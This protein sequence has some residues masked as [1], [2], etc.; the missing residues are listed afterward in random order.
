[1]FYKGQRKTL[2][3]ILF[4][5]LLLTNL[6][7]MSLNS[8][9]IDF[10]MTTKLPAQNSFDD[11]ISLA[12]IIKFFKKNIKTLVSF[13]LLGGLLGGLYGNFAGPV[14]E[15]SMLIAPAK[16]AGNYVIDPKI[17]LTKLNM[18]S[19]Y[20]KETFLA[21]NPSFY[22]D[23]DIDYDMSD[24]VK[25]SLS[26][27]GSLINF[28][29]QNK[30]KDI[31]IGCLSSTEN[32]IKLSQSAIALTFIEMKKNELQL[33]QNRLILSE[34][35]RKKLND[36]QLKDLK[37]TE[38]RFST[39]LLYAN[40]VLNKDAEIKGLMDQINKL[41]TDLSSEQ[42]KEASKVLPINIERKNFPSL[43]LGL[44]LGLFLGGMLGFFVSFFRKIKMD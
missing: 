10:H 9:Q 44:L 25:T 30:I 33:A 36:K 29:M 27:D 31:I 41:T 38:L 12:D 14:F 35:F 8:L 19:Y 1:M 40:I 23:K 6:F 18:N 7:I 34:E 37:T 20:S 16:V 21:C 43:K 42:T 15:G 13:L 5:C 3:K 11:E 17:T 4:C 28:T 2:F 39:D 32:D 24:I 26:K 22:K